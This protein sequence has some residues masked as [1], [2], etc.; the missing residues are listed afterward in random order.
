[1]R[2]YGI[3]GAR[4]PTFM[5]TVRF[6]SS[7]GTED[8]PTAVQGSPPSAEWRALDKAQVRLTFWL[9]MPSGCFGSGSPSAGSSL[10]WKCHNEH[11]AFLLRNSTL[12]KGPKSLLS[13]YLLSGPS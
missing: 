13:S 5:T 2:S 7:E 6:R 1:M 10:M 3:C 8:E 12:V 4:K 11:Q 9:P